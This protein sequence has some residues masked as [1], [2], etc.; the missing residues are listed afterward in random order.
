M[1]PS[2]LGTAHDYLPEWGA[3]QS[4]VARF[5]GIGA[6]RAS[7]ARSQGDSP[8]GA[9]PDQLYAAMD[10]KPETSWSPRR[11]RPA[12][13]SGS[14]RPR[15]PDRVTR[16]EVGFDLKADTLPTTV[17]VTAGYESRIVEQFSD[18]MVFDLPG[19]HVTRAVPISIDEAYD[20]RPFGNGRWHRRDQDSRRPDQPDL[21]L[22]A[23]PA[24]DRP[25]TSACRRRPP[26]P[27]CCSVDGHPRCSTD[28]VRGSEDASTIGRTF[29]L[30]PPANTNPSWG[31][32]DGRPGSGQRP[33]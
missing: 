13:A 2:G 15:Q 33:R 22:P 14:G 32:A 5:E 30:P 27:A 9:C 18:H 29:T 26:R 11:T 17:T 28:A 20:L 10:G 6:I 7:T 21:V 3:Q 8:G 24:I 19:V 31:A 16:V 1:T 25:A 23:A 4:T 12:T